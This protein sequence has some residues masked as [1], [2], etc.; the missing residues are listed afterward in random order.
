MT[1]GR[2]RSAPFTPPEDD[3]GILSGTRDCFSWAAVAVYCLTG[4]VPADYGALEAAAAD[5]ADRA[6]VP[7]EILRTALSNDPTERPPLASALL[8]DS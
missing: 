3:S 6:D 5:L 7:V 8:A 4:K 2:F 1:L